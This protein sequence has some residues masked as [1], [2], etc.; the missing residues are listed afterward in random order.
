MIKNIL[1]EDQ[2]R[3]LLEPPQ[4]IKILIEKMMS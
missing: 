2:M 3:I 4:K 1:D